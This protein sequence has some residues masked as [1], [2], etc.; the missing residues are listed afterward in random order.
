MRK[1][2]LFLS[3]FVVQCLSSQESITDEQSARNYFESREY[4]KAETYLKRLFP[5]NPSKF[6]TMTFKTYLS[7]KNYEDAISI[8]QV[9][10]KQD[11]Q[12][13][14]Y[15]YDLGFMFFKLNDSAQGRKEWN[16]T[17]DLVKENLDRSHQ[18]I[19]LFRSNRNWT[20]LE[21]LILTISPASRLSQNL[22]EILMD[23]YLAQKKYNEAVSLI[24]K[25]IDEDEVNYMNSLMRIQ[26]F[27]DEKDLMAVVQKKVYGKYSENQNSEKWLQMAM[28]VSQI[29]KDYEEAILISK[30]YDKR[31][32]G[33]GGFVLSASDIAYNEGEIDAAI[34]GYH[35]LTTI[36]AN[37]SM[38]K[39]GFEK[40][41]KSYVTKLERSLKNDSNLVG[42]IEELMQ[43]YFSK[44]SMDFTTAEIQ[45]LK[46]DLSVRYLNN[47]EEGIAILKRLSEF[48]QL[49]NQMR[50]RARLNL[51][52][53][54]L[55]AG[56]IWE[57]SL[58]Y[59]QVDKEEMDSPLGEEARFKNSKIFYYNGDFELAADL[60]S[61]LKSSTTELLAND[62]LY[63]S[64]FIQDNLDNDTFQAA[65]REISKA[66][67]YFCQNKSDIALN[68]LKD[69]KFKFP[70]SNLID[71]VLMIEATEA[72]RSR[73]FE[74]AASLYRELE[75][76]Y[77][78]SILSDKAVYE[79]AK[80]EEIYL[81]NQPKAMDGYF[82]ILTKYKDS[83]YTTE[84][85]RRFRK[86]RG[87]KEEEL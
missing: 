18:L 11:K 43:V 73:N 64:V 27:I 33:N 60:L 81:K 39:L 78:S 4:Q 25:S 63:L 75:E 12:N 68:I 71:D 82:K 83:V 51:A 34:T 40:E 55:M 36:L 19:E 53:Y 76:K 3:F 54:K 38:A 57:A 15:R 67:L 52:D 17:I 62:A 7:L 45:I 42:R 10:L 31:N 8:C 22:Q 21:R 35:Y 70:N 29:T 24:V 74:K 61:I 23:A 72:S 48:A 58:I 84:A 47:L 16:K 37:N 41:I 5:T 20:Y 44:Y 2:L 26:S 56:D 65:L 85:R 87:E 6:Y 9:A 50:S 46:A 86:L 80:I 28:W 14:G 49:Q 66:E 59:G 1:T 30:A 79:W 69:I 13:I 77:P 32:Q